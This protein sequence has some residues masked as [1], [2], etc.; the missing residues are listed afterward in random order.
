MILGLLPAAGTNIGF[1]MNMAIAPPEKAV[2]VIL[3]KSRR[4]LFNGGLIWQT[5]LNF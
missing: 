3:S 1:S 5:S 2:L 4:P